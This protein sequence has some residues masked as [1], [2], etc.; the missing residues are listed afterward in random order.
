MT[1]RA[2]IQCGE[3]TPVPVY[4]DSLISSS[5]LPSKTS[6]DQYRSVAPHNGQITTYWWK[7]EIR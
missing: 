2:W 7:R 3:K 6:D 4:R 1:M 5:I